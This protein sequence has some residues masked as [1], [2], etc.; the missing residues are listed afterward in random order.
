M[1]TISGE[2]PDHAVYRTELA[3]QPDRAWQLRIDGILVA[4]TRD[5]DEH[6]E[7]L[8]QEQAQAWARRQMGEGVRFL[9]GL[10]TEPSGFWVATPDTEQ[11]AMAAHH[12]NPSHHQDH[13]RDCDN[14]GAVAL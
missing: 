1:T 5:L 11:R 6:Q 8:D 14:S 12:R 7:P 4:E 13:D 3:Q 10:V 9:N 2:E